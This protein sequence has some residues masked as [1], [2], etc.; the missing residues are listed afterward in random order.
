MKKMIAFILVLAM[1]LCALPIAVGAASGTFEYTVLSDGTAQITGYTADN[2]DSVTAVV[3]PSVLDGYTVTSVGDEAFR[4]YPYVMMVS[5]PTSVTSVGKYA[6][7]D[8]IR[9]FDVAYD[10]TDAQWEA[11][12]PHIDPSNG[13]L[14]SADVQF[15]DRDAGWRYTVNNAG[16]VTPRLYIGPKEGTSFA[17]PTT[18][19]GRP[20][21]V[22]SS[23]DPN[24]F[25]F[26]AWDELETIVIPPSVTDLGGVSFA[27]S[28]IKELD[29]PDTVENIFAPSLSGIFEDCTQLTRVKLSEAMTS[30]PSFAFKDCTAL[31]TVSIPAGCKSIGRSAF[32]NCTSLKTVTI[33]EYDGGG[34]F[35]QGSAFKGCTALADVYFGGTQIQW[36]YELDVRSGNEP[37][38]GATIHFAGGTGV[39]GDAD[40]DGTVTMRDALALYQAVAGTETLSDAAMKV[41][42]MDNDGA[43]TM[44]D[45]LKL[46]GNTAVG[47]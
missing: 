22:I 16:G 27:G 15:V 40:Q 1:L 33:P 13:N 24:T 4:G 8:A 29:I 35:I 25:A 12:V 10:G 37:L 18:V 26:Q 30:V 5:I 6:F 19:A 7:G 43:F 21:T 3:I 2:A 31:E 42:D 36:E 34:M 38:L 11:L 41:S 20:V 17:F 45:V 39:A 9:L 14:L 32:E 47:A 23:G 44:R 46:Y 28:A